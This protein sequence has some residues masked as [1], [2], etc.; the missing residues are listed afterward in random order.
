MITLLPLI[1]T[2]HSVPP[3][4]GTELCAF[5]P[6]SRLSYFSEQH[7]ILFLLKMLNFP[8]R[9]NKVLLL[10]QTHANSVSETA[11]NLTEPH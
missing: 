6:F 1:H 4:G 7:Y 2:A 9:C 11:S 5:Y 10:P 3:P 8:S